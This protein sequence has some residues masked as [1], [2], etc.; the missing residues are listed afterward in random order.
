MQLFLSQLSFQNWF[1]IYKILTP[2]RSKKRP[3]RSCKIGVKIV[4][5]IELGFKNKSQKKPRTKFLALVLY[6]RL[7]FTSK[8]ERRE[9]LFLRRK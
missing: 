8:S 2:T 9:L 6:K 4:L 5:T 1:A 7:H 3:C